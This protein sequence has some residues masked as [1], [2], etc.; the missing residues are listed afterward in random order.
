MPVEIA[1]IDA[2]AASTGIQ[3]AI[4]WAPRIAA[5]FNAR[6]LHTLK[7]CVE[8]IVTDMK[9]I[10]VDVERISIIEVQG[11]FIV[12]LHRGKMPAAPL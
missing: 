1:K 4:G 3:L 9:G 10:M 2:P 5:P 8:F 11:Q 12:D 6:I 7:D